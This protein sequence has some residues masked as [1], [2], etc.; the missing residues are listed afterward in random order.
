MNENIPIIGMRRKKVAT[1]KRY[2]N[3]E[4]N[5]QEKGTYRLLLIAASL[6]I[7]SL[8]A[9]ERMPEGSI[10]EEEKEPTTFSP[11]I[12]RNLEQQNNRYTYLYGDNNDTLPPVYYP[13]R[14]H[15]H[16][17]TGAHFAYI[18]ISYNQKLPI[19][20]AVVYMG[21]DRIDCDCKIIFS[22]LGDKKHVRLKLAFA[23][24]QDT[25]V[26][27]THSLP[28][29]EGT[30]HYRYEVQLKKFRSDDENRQR[31]AGEWQAFKNAITA[32]TITAST[33]YDKASLCFVYTGRTIIAL[34]IL[35]IIGFLVFK[36]E[37]ARK[38]KER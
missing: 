22:K 8:H 4:T 31:F 16:N 24:G 1:E 23:Y 15:M 14:L 26:C 7:G 32:T 30:S 28:I 6:S 2:N 19:Y 17:I 11:I 12:A 21:D 35:S 13:L 5:R 25:Y 33:C 27:T 10:S 9:M 34:F 37:E 38:A 36:M 3:G 20:C 18:A 29:C